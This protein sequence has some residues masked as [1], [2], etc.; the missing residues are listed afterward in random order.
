MGLPVLA[1]LYLEITSPIILMMVAAFLAH[2][3]TVYADLR[4]A[5]SKREVTP[6]EQMVHSFMEMMPLVGIWLVSVLREDELRALLGTS[7]R[8]PDF[9]VRLK[10]QPLPPGYRRGL[11]TAIALFGAIPYIEELWR[12]ARVAVSGNFPVHDSQRLRRL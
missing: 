8:R 5:V 11:L 4:I 10:E 12:T 9:S 7:P 6:T 3:A 2:E 1:T